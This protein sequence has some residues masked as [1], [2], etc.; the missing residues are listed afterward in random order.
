MDFFVHC[1]L[2]LS[3]VHDTT[4]VNGSLIQLVFVCHLYVRTCVDQ[5]T[6]ASSFLYDFLWYFCFV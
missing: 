4:T 1:D 3:F 6:V 2:V 5:R